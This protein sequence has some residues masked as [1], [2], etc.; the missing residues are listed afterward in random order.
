MP[1][2]LLAAL[3]GSD[4]AG[5]RAIQDA[6]LSGLPN[7]DVREMGTFGDAASLW[8]AARR[9]A[10]VVVAGASLSDSRQA[11]RNGGPGSAAS[12]STLTRRPLAL[13]GVG[14]G[15][16]DR[17]SASARARWIVG[18]ASL[19]LLAD[20]S[21]AA[22]LAAAGA[23]TPLRISADP[24]W[25]VLNP[26][27]PTPARD[28]SVAVALDG[29][30]GPAV[31]SALEAALITVARAGRRVR[32]VP[33]AGSASTDAALG[34]R[35]ARAV[36]T[37]VP[38]AAAIEPTPV[39]LPEAAALFA[40]AYA[41]VAFRYRAIHAAAAAGVPIVAVAVEERLAALGTRLGQVVVAPSHLG[42]AL[43]IALERIEPWG[44]PNAATVQEE[45]IRARAGM[46]LL[47]LVMEPDAVGP[48]EVDHLPLSPEPWL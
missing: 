18:R 27:G 31:E 32:I 23:P 8:N 21:S 20:E 40:D 15:T 10:G 38:G 42:T 36:G 4:P 34:S 14:A 47:R 48:A 39:T 19:T 2:V 44:G 6:V 22:H 7:H 12:V 25:L 28:E 41:V 37:E 16:L 33:W 17:P 35:L 3:P 1:S 30:L 45:I 9:S 5:R 26:S 24:A 43:P 13:V 46:R 11:H 29:G